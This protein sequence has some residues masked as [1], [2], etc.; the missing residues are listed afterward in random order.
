MNFRRSTI[1]ALLL[2]SAPA[3][4]AACPI[5]QVDLLGYVLDP[6]GKAVVGATVEA[7]WE[8]KAAGAVSTRRETMADGSFLLKIAY[9]TYS[10]KTFT[11]KDKCETRLQGAQ[12]AVEMEGFVALRQPV[13]FAKLPDSL[14]L[15]LTP[16]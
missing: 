10:G 4:H 5:E 12:L 13:S 7:S 8:E 15:T 14:T 1:A 9:D 3:A 2:L 16:R 11:G 6:G